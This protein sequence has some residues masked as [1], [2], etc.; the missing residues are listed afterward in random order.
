MDHDLSDFFGPATRHRLTVGEKEQCYEEL[1]TRMASVHLP[2]GMRSVES[3]S[4]LWRALGGVF[5][6]WT[7]V[8]AV[9]IVLVLTGTGM[10]F[11][12]SAMPGDA[13]YGLKRLGEQDRSKIH[14]DTASKAEVEMDHLDARLSEADDLDSKGK[15][16][17]A[18]TASLD[19][20]F[21]AE[22]TQVM[23]HVQDLEKQ[24]PKPDVVAR[25]RTRLKTYEDRYARTLKMRRQGS[26]MRAGAGSGHVLT[27]S[28]HMITGSGS[29][30]AGSGASKNRIWEL[31]QKIRHD[32]RDQEQMTQ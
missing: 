13:L 31:H 32:I 19:D 14:W 16:T 8:A 24:A 27:G 28:G 25:I 29:H 15:L 20:D 2:G 4:F 22:H 1:C 7:P 18:V 10:T 21:V 12:Q 30:L 23:V 17:E 3:G 9:V 11:A 5:S 6:H 26:R